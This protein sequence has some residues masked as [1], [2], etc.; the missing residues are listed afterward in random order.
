[1]STDDHCS[2]PAAMVTSLEIK[3]TREYVPL[4]QD[5]QYAV[6]DP[7]DVGE[8]NQVGRAKRS[9]EIVPECAMRHGPPT[10][11]LMF[12]GPSGIVFD[13]SISREN[14]FRVELE[15]SNRSNSE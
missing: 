6:L 11:V 10:I 15:T 5:R 3:N 2:I 4:H 7:R 14:V 9:V 1:M 12:H 8:M 13:I